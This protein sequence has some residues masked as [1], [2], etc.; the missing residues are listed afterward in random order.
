MAS[1]RSGSI[2]LTA[3]RVLSAP[4]PATPASPLLPVGG[5]GAGAA[6]SGGC[7]GG[8]GGCG[9]V[10]CGGGVAGLGGNALGAGGSGAGLGGDGGGDGG[11]GVGP[12][13]RA[14]CDVAEGRGVCDGAGAGAWGGVGGDAADGCGGG[15]SG[16]SRHV[17]AF[18]L[19]PLPLRR[20]PVRLPCAGASGL[21]SPSLEG[22]ATAPVPGAVAAGCNP[23][24]I[25]I[26][27][28]MCRA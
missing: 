18:P 20:L 26:N 7:G 24:R 14:V 12:G 17:G 2:A 21:A 1:V 15:G 25:T 13:V 5:G 28:C 4:T 19:P 22:P 27:I 6:P 11:G 9:G 8:P 16:F 23:A 3:S 10:A